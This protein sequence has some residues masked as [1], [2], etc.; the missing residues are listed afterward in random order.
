MRDEPKINIVR[1][2]VTE[3]GKEVKAVSVVETLTRNQRKKRRRREVEKEKKEKAAREAQ[4]EYKV[5]AADETPPPEAERRKHALDRDV[6]AKLEAVVLTTRSGPCG[7]S[8]ARKRTRFMS[9]ASS[10]LDEFG[11]LCGGEHVHQPLL[12]NRA[13]SAASIQKDF[14]GPSAEGWFEK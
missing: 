12:Q 13:A 2:L 10:I 14:V 4:G 8:P 9:N 7:W 3:D 6:E 1:A 5:E 11:K